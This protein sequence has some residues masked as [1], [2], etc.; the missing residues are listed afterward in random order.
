MQTKIAG[1]YRIELH[2]LPA[3]PFF[4][5]DEVADKHV[6]EGMQIEGG[7]A[8][9][10]PNADS[11]PNHHLVVHIFDKQT[12][13]VVT[14]ASVTMTFTPLDAN[15][16]PSVTPVT[17][18]I[19]VMQAVGSGPQ[20]THYGNNVTMPAGRYTV[21]VTVNGSGASFAVRA[22]DTPSAPMGHMNMKM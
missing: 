12:G 3:E 5:K 8:P 14:D 19:V 16:K 20:S 15:G 13:K 2:V 7:A 1:S 17:V 21:M 6:K 9:V 22:S 10:A 4:T 11:H 18:P